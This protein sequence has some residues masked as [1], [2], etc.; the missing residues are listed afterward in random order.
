MRPTELFRREH[1]ELHPHIEHVKH[2][3]REV[4]RLEHEEREVL[5]GR[6]IGFLRGT[7]VPHAKAEDVLYPEWAKLVG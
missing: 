4:A 3:A 1:E 7:L 5:V 2:A 6:I